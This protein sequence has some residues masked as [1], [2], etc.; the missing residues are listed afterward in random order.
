MT[1]F[2]FDTAC[3]NMYTVH[4]C[5]LVAYECIT[6]FLYPMCIY[7]TILVV[8]SSQ[9]VMDIYLHRQHLSRNVTSQDNKPAEVEGFKVRYTV[10]VCHLVPDCKS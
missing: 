1:V 6:S 4:M 7:N 3:V 8:W 9:C 2:C 5:I 10:F